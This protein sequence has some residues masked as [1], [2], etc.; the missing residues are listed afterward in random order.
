MLL[1][2]SHDTMKPFCLLLPFIL[3]FR[4][5]GKDPIP[6]KAINFL[7]FWSRDGI[8]IFFGHLLLDLLIGQHMILFF[9]KIAYEK[10]H[11][12]IGSK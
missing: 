6:V 4:A 8:Q 3:Q 7:Y 5:S 2:I 9:P 11:L 10:K 1:T 12:V